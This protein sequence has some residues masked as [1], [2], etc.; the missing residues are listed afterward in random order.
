MIS[1]QV[2]AQ[3]HRFDPPWNTPPESKLNFTVPGIDN[4][5]DLF[6]D[7]IDPQL[8]VFFAGNQFMCIDDLIATFKKEYPQYKRVF[9]ETLPPGILATQIKVG[10]LVIG[11]M[12]IILKPD[13]YTAGKSRIAQTPEWFT[14]TEVYA[15]N[16]LTI[17]VQKG[18]PKNINGLKDLARNDVRVSMPNPEWEGIGR[19][20]EE[21]YIK[22][23]GENLKNMIMINK[24]KDSSTFLTHIHH[25]QS[26][27]R[28]LYDQSD[29]A[30]VWFSEGYYQK[31]IRHPV[32]TIEIPESENIEAQ[33]VAGR[34]KNAPH[35]QAANDFM[36][37]LVSKIAKDIYKKYGFETD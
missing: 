26:P 14:N 27:M 15:K 23:G 37:F 22:A 36:K 21:A 6:G 1:A 5:P 10:S 25:R 11:N 7:I 34:L 31:M 33:Y 20:I 19:R 30:P 17:M 29:A 3:D 9:A 16:K 8:V 13:V 18:N 12:R 35:P 4:V 2:Y 28:I 32:E 24:V